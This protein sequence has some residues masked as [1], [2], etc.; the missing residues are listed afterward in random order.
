MT[1]VYLPEDSAWT[2]PVSATDD[3][4]AN[5]QLE[6][7]F[8]GPDSVPALL[9]QFALTGTLNGPTVTGNL[10]SAAGVFDYDNPATPK[11]WTLK[12]T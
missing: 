11:T 3:N 2:A 12:M 7:T 4:G 5:I 8:V 1:Y 9:P 6:L 10:D